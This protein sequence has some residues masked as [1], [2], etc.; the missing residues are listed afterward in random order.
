MKSKIENQK[1]TIDNRKSKIA[2]D[3]P[4]GSGKST[5][6][7]LI[8]RKLRFLYI[9]S[10]AMYR[11]VTLYMIKKRLLDMPE[12]NLS[13]YIRSIKINFVNKKN[14]QFIFLNGKDVTKKIRSGIVN[15]NVSK[16]SAKKVVRLEMV[17]RQKMFALKDSVVMD[18]RD[19]GTNV[20]KDADLKIYLTATSEIRAKRRMKDI[21]KIGEKISFKDL[22]KEIQAR[23]N[24]DSARSISPLCKAQDAVVIDSTDLTV[25]EVLDQI[26]VFFKVI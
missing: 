23:D 1:S 4:A 15:K 22:V 5:I 13:K 19:I 14:K 26:N 8:A 24:Y 21:K 6:A 20:F 25:D 11:A 3:G 18:G 16:V 12:K 7:K 9:D 10:G 2:I 17:K